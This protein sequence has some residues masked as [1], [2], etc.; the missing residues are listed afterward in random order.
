MPNMFDYLKNKQIPF[1]GQR[2]PKSPHKSQALRKKKKTP[3]T[4]PTSG[5][6]CPSSAALWPTLRPALHLGD[7][8]RVSKRAGRTGDDPSALGPV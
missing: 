5:G 8:S 7:L 6:G 3:A 1:E 4:P 2:Q